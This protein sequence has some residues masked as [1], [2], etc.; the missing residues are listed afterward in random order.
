LELDDP[1]Y[2]FLIAGNVDLDGLTVEAW[3]GETCVA[4]LFCG[5]RS[6]EMTFSCDKEIPLQLVEEMI[7]IARNKQPPANTYNFLL[8]KD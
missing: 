6:K 8:R 1:R 4:E 3:E 2:S 5:Y 7:D